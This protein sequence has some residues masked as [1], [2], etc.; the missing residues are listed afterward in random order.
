MQEACVELTL[1]SVVQILHVC[2]PRLVTALFI[3]I[4]EAIVLNMSTIR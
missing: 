3:R 2:A 1:G 4:V